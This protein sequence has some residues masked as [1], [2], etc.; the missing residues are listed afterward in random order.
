[1]LFVVDSACWV[2]TT[3]FYH[4]LSAAKALQL[5]SIT[6]IPLGLDDP[7]S[8]SGVSSLLI[9]F[10]NSA[11]K[12]TISSGDVKP[13]S[14]IVVS[15]NC[16][17]H[18]DMRYAS[19]VCVFTTVMI[20]YYR[21]MCRCLLIEFQDPPVSISTSQH[22]GGDVE[23]VWSTCIGFCIGLGDKFF[24][25]GIAELVKMLE[26][27]ANNSISPRVL[28]A[29]ATLLWFAQEVHGIFCLIKFYRFFSHFLDP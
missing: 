2:H 16:V 15:T 22:I 5:C 14:S 11:K 18:Q 12:S 17:P 10:F 8:K 1:M 7:D 6:N 3:R 4:H 27:N 19:C 13:I 21:F 29:Y 20:S 25:T 9:D 26:S 23:E 24:H 28:P